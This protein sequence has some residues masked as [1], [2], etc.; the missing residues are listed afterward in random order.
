MN[1]TV[2]RVKA[3]LCWK[4]LNRDIK[5]FIQCCSICQQNKDDTVA[6]PGLLQPLPIP[7]TIWQHITIDFIEGLPNTEGKQVIFVVVD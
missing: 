6:N 2:R 1:V 3:V 7:Q 5:Y 4:G